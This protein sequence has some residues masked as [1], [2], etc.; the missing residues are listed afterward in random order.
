MNIGLCGFLNLHNTCYF[1]SVIQLIMRNPSF[2]IYMQSCNSTNF[3]D[4]SFTHELKKI[5]DDY[6]QQPGVISPRS[7][8]NYFYRTFGYFN[9]GQQHDAHECLN[10]MLDAIYEESIKTAHMRIKHKP[11]IIEE[12][13]NLMSL[14]N[15]DKRVIDM[16]IKNNECEFEKYFGFQYIQ[17]L[18]SKKFNPFIQDITVFQIIKICCNDCKHKTIKYDH[19]PILQID[20]KDNLLDCLNDYTLTKNTTDYK[21][22]ICNSMNNNIMTK[23][24]RNPKS[25]Y[26]QIKRFQLNFTKQ[27]Y[28]K[29]NNVVFMPLH[30]NLKNYCHESIINKKDEDFEYAYVGCINHHNRNMNGGHYTTEIKNIYDKKFYKF[31]DSN[32]Y[33][34]KNNMISDEETYIALYV[35]KS[36]LNN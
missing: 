27:N 4:K 36:L 6:I 17:N 16:L 26:I 2:I 28:E 25:L 3:N 1:N 14:E 32:V 34:N 22:D 31:D 19:T 21:C 23:I 8:L 24:F 15:M 7:L 30:F 29:N 35:L 18:Y 13:E 12:Y 10:L 5:Y 20:V 11:A 9:D 33:E